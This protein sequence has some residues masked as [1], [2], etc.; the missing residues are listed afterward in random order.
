MK[1]ARIIVFG[2]AAVAGGLAWL[3]ASNISAPPPP[4]EASAAAPTVDMTPVLV[5]RHDL[6]IGERLSPSSMEWQDWPTANLA[7]T[8]I[9]ETMTP[10]AMRDFDQGI[11]TTPIYSGEP[12]RSAEIAIAGRGFMSALLP[13]GSRAIS[14][15]VQTEARA[16]GFILPNDRIDV[17]LTRVERGTSREGGDIFTSE[18]ILSNVRVLAIDQTFEERDGEQ[19]V[20]G[21]IATLE[22]SPGEAELIALAD[23]MGG[24]SLSLR[25]I[26]DIDEGTEIDEDIARRLRGGGGQ[27]GSVRM[28]RFGI[29]G[30]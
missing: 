8:F 7:E 11:V 28:I 17:I 16:A 14:I 30:G 1:S 24:L 23:E 5:A 18:T 20:T 26:A 22:L 21:E 25:S 9:S 10:D 12:I 2:V 19:F 13:S 27:G 29:Q 3:L 4:Q 15:R 6:T